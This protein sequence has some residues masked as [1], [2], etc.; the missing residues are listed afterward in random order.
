[1]HWSLEVRRKPRIESVL[2]H[3]RPIRSYLDLIMALKD[4]QSRCS[5]TCYFVLMHVFYVMR[6]QV[7]A[8]LVDHWVFWSVTEKCV[9]LYGSLTF[10]AVLI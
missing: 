4:W 3:L 5:V 2:V 6:V 1:M 8:Q 7:L 9:D 10:I